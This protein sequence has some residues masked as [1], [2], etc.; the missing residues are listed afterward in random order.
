MPFE[1]ERAKK[2]F[3]EIVNIIDNENIIKINGLFL[4]DFK[5]PK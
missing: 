1:I 4:H 5:F 2:F 3:S